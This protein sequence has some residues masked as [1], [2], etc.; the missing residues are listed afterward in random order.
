[1]EADTKIISEFDHYLDESGS[2]MENSKDKFERA[3]DDQDNPRKFPS[4]L[5]GLL[6]P[7]GALTEDKAEEILERCH[8]TVGWPLPNIVHLKDYW[9]DPDYNPT[10]D[11][12]AF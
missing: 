4:Q 7:R 12:K 1:M 8:N 3:I 11:Q 9:K 6:V 2:F 5:A 10:Q